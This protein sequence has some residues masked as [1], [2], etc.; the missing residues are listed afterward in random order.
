MKAIE[1][2]TCDLEFILGVKRT[3]IS[4]SQVW[5]SRPPAAAGSDKLEEFLD[6]VGSPLAFPHIF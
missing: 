4:L 2:F 5:T 3:E 1:T 6:E